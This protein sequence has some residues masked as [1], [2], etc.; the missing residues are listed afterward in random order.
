M[1]FEK[2]IEFW[3]MKLDAED[4]PT[5]L[6]YNNSPTNEAAPYYSVS[7]TLPS[8]ISIRN[9]P[10]QRGTSSSLYDSAGRHPVFAAQIYE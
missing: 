9:P 5:T 1:A 2:E 10:L 4:T 6:P 8:E 3:K 7:V